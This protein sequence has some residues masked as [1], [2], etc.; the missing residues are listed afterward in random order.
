[1]SSTSISQTDSL[2]L[3]DSV[4]DNSND[5]IQHI[6]CAPSGERT[7][8]MT[9][10]CGADVTFDSETE[11]DVNCESCLDEAPKH[12]KCVQLGGKCLLD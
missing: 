2:E 10:I 6:V 1:M 3:I 9:A 11:V 7:V 5:D 4:P 12:L 8:P